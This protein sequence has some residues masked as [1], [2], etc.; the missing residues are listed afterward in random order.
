LP[1]KR[2]ATSAT[3]LERERL[4][5]IGQSDIFLK[6]VELIERLG[7]CDATTLIDG[8][9]GTG[10]EV[11]A[12]AIHYLSARRDF[13][14]IPVHCGALPDSLLEAELFGHEKGAFTDA[15]ERRTGLITEAD[16]GTLFLD[17]VEAMTPRAQVVLLRFLQDQS[18][19][20][21]G[22]RTLCRADVRIIAAT[23]AGL[24]ELIERGLFRRDLWFR[25]RVLELG[26]PPLRQRRGDATLLAH[27]FLSRLSVNYGKPPKGL[28]PDTLECLESHAWP[29]NVR[30]LE[31]L[32]LREFLL[33]DN[34][35][36]LIRS[37]PNGTSK[38]SHP[39]RPEMPHFEPVFKSAKALALAD[40][41]ESYLRELLARTQGN[42]SRA[43]VLARKDRSALNKLVRKHG[44]VCGDFQSGGVNGA[45]S[46]KRRSIRS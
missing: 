30:E 38:A 36:V 29:G 28:H 39:A 22:G 33:H 43:A 15:K 13:P 24:P 32:M 10:K 37:M 31:S 34:D 45:E 2:S 41:E 9:T 40:F 4:N 16:S 14:F 8:E 1:A 6:T 3:P 44:L 27:H 25:L 20:A 26:L 19:R 12:R 46:L 11:A 7:A 23:N 42:I 21:V 18:Y 5:L 35:E 17:E